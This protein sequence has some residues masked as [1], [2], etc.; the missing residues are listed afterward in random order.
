MVTF[1]NI[2]L[3]REALALLA[4]QCMVV[5]GS[6]RVGLVE[7]HV[8]GPAVVIRHIDRDCRVF[9]IV[10]VARRE[11]E[12]AQVFEIAANGTGKGTLN[13]AESVE[14]PLLPLGL[15]VLPVGALDGLG[16]LPVLPLERQSA[17]P[18]EPVGVIL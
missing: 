2:E 13:R 4:T 6:E 12:A 18:V 3:H 5:E 9:E 11:T 17:A 7:Q 15:G 8:E 1:T 16:V 14:G 10:I